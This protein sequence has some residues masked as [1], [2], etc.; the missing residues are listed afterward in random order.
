MKDPDSTSTPIRL[1]ALGQ[2]HQFFA[3][4]LPAGNY[5]VPAAERESYLEI[6][7]RMETALYRF[8][9]GSQETLLQMWKLHHEG[10]SKQLSKNGKS[11]VPVV[12]VGVWPNKPPPAVWTREEFEAFVPG[13]MPRP[14]ISMVFRLKGESRQRANVLPLMGG[15]GALIQAW[16]QGDAE[17]FY[18]D[19]E[20]YFRTFITEPLHL[21][22]P[23]FFPLLDSATLPSIT[24]ELA[25]R[26]LSR[27]QCYIRES[28]EDRGV[29]IL[30]RSSLEP[31]LKELY[32]EVEPRPL[33]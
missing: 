19:C 7:A 12:G 17:E 6:L 33:L 29:L 21:A 11:W 32:W 26:L 31:V 1:Q 8:P 18:K 22:Y 20:Q 16:I 2:Q 23:F 25:D 9:S 24:A 5:P 14:P 13:E 27:V 3:Y 30:S 28:S 10:A 15:R 4:L